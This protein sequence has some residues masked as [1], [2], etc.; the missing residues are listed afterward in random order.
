[1][2]SVTYIKPSEGKF[3]IKDVK[4]PNR[5][6]NNLYKITFFENLGKSMDYQE[7]IEYNQKALKEGNPIVPS[8]PDYFA[9]LDK[10]KN[11]NDFMNFNRKILKKKWID[12]HSVVNYMTKGQKDKIIHYEGLPWEYSIEGNFAGKKDSIFNLRNEEIFNSIAGKTSRQMDF[13][14]NSFNEIN[15]FLNRVEY[16]SKYLEKKIVAKLRSDFNFFS[17]VLDGYPD[18]NN[19]VF[20]VAIEEQ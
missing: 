2:E 16:Q 3:E 8:M 7:I 13:I 17:L 20:R 6:S 18:F 15:F 14:S 4:L 5:N 9:I 10:G 12:F 11:S 1:M 19:G